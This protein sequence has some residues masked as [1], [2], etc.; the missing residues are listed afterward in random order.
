MLYP[1][2]IH[3]CTLPTGIR[4]TVYQIVSFPTS[5]E[6]PGSQLVQ[7]TMRQKIS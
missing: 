1:H 5:K 6:P 2:S 3:G 4:S 7:Q